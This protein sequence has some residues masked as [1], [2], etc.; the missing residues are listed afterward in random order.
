MMGKKENII[1]KSD[2]GVFIPNRLII[3]WR[4]ITGNAWMLYEL[5]LALTD[6]LPKGTLK[7]S[8]VVLAKQLGTDTRTVNAYFWWLQ[9]VGLLAI[10]SDET[11]GNIIQLQSPEGTPTQEL[12]DWL[13]KEIEET[14]EISERTKPGLRALCRKWQAVS[15]QD[16]VAPN[17]SVVAPPDNTPPD[18]EVA[19][20]INNYPDTEQDNSVWLEELGCTSEQTE[21]LKH[22]DKIMLWAIFAYIVSKGIKHKC[23]Y[24]HKQVSQNYPLTFTQFIALATWWH[25]ATEQERTQLEQAIRTNSYPPV[26]IPEA[27]LNVARSIIKNHGSLHLEKQRGEIGSNALATVTTSRD[28]GEG[29]PPLPR[30][31]W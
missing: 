21:F 3:H 16:F 22:K 24:L 13:A 29:R 15:M 7:V 17:V 6:E 28:D 12:V 8:T 26:A 25:A 10:S 1:K 31:A 27:A 2:A 4:R 9:K 19:T 20:T 18:K 5:L 14:D 30:G 11:T 23:G